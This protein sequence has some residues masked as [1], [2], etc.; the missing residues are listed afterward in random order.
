MFMLAHEFDD[1]ASGKIAWIASG[2][3]QKSVFEEQAQLK[4]D[5]WQLKMDQL[6]IL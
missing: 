5:Q 4:M 6:S 2:D 1:H 3:E